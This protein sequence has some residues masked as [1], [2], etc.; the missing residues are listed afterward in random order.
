M[1][2]RWLRSRSSTRDE[3]SYSTENIDM[4]SSST[5]LEL[6]ADIPVRANPT[7]EIGVQNSEGTAHD[8]NNATLSNITSSQLQ[9]LLT[10]VMAAIQ[11]ECSKQTAAFQA[12]VAKLTETLKAQLSQENEKLAASLTE[13]FDAANKKLTEE[14]NA[15]LQHEIQ[16]VSDKVD[17]LKTDTEQSIGNLTKSVGDLKEE[18]STRVSAHIVQTRKELDKQRQEIINNSKVVLANIREHK[19]E[20]ESTL[21]N[22]RQTVTQ[23]RGQVDDL[24]N[25][26]SS[27]VRSS[28]QE[29][30]SQIQRIKHTNEA[31][32]MK[33][34]K[35]ISSLEDKITAGG[36]SNNRPTIPKT[37]VVRTTAVGQPESTV[38]TIGS[39]SSVI[40]ASGANACDM[41]TCSDSA[42]VPN[43]PVNSC[44]ENVNALSVVV[45]NGCTDLT[46]LSLPKF[47]NSAKQVVAHFLRELDEYFAL[48][49]TP[50]ELKL[51]LCFRAIEDPFAKQ[52]FATVYDTVGTY[53]NFKT[54]FANLLWGQTRQAQI[55]CSIY[56][57]RWDRRNEETCRALYPLCKY[58]I[59]AEPTSVGGGPSWSHDRAFSDGRTKRHGLQEPKDNAGRISF[60]EQNA[61][62]GN[63]ASATYETA[64][65][66]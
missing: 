43:T 4:D 14:F 18:T 35:V 59:N 45:P 50:N 23:N 49:K 10:T 13:R 36:P 48:K 6:E 30:E 63:R 1:T 7:V 22:L 27:E 51:A 8:S 53:E 39:E 20:T 28:L 42:N 31:E 40:G 26:V 62:I 64:P 25:S 32:I 56:Q 11:A 46:E 66:V 15:K 52:W 2:E 17:T 19:T 47:N 44:N 3:G 33:I 24:L 12:E 29:C 60:F 57:D 61:G 21:A 9:D 54:A 5:C 55:R 58:G 41:S 38:G 34:N 37:A 65:R 16:G